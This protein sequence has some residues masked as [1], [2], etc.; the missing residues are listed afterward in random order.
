M[1][2]ERLKDGKGLKESKDSKGQKNNLREERVQSKRKAGMKRNEEIKDFK[3]IEAEE[4]G[5]RGLNT[6]ADPEK[7]QSVSAAVTQL[8]AEQLSR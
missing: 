6:S 3:K 1:K 4:E 5:T 2:S 8:T 7:W